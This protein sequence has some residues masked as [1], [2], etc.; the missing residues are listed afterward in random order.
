MQGKY[1]QGNTTHLNIFVTSIGPKYGG[2]AYL[3]SQLVTKK[4]NI[5]FL[6]GVVLSYDVL[7][8]VDNSTGMNLGTTAV[9]EVGHWLGL[10]HTFQGGCKA[11]PLQGDM[12]V[13]DTPAEKVAYVYGDCSAQ[14]DTCTGR[15]FP[16]YNPITN[17][18]DYS[19]NAC[20]TQFTKG[21]VG[22]FRPSGQLMYV[23]RT[24]VSGQTINCP[25]PNQNPGHRM[26]QQY[27]TYRLF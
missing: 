26:L 22:S 4:E 7:P 8:G 3:P 14:V 12:V 24:L 16:G 19:D 23:I 25:K 11:N 20:R 15:R 1:K 18:I 6:D 17:H 21:Q 9:H 5:L 27:I 2:Y 10:Y 13:S